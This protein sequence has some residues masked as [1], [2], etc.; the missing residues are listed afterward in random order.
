MRRY[1]LPGSSARLTASRHH[2]CSFAAHLLL[3]AARAAL[4]W[5][6]LGASSSVPQLTWPEF[7]S[8]I[9]VILF[10]YGAPHSFSFPGCVVARAQAQASAAP[11]RGLSRPYVWPPEPQPPSDHA[12]AHSCSVL[13]APLPRGLALLVPRSSVGLL[14]DSCPTACPPPAPPTIRG[15]SGGYA[16]SACLARTRAARN[17]AYAFSGLKDAKRVSCA[18]ACAAA[19]RARSSACASCRACSSACR[20]SSFGHYSIIPILGLAS[21]RADA[22][23]I[24][25]GAGHPLTAS[26]PM[27]RT[28]KLDL[29]ICPVVST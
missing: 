8:V 3:T 29:P 7:F 16:A 13:L 20:R 17:S 6:W 23:E 12:P 24:D 18:D 1:D 25:T 21:L 11:R 4:W 14:L 27:V 22:S 5:P 19:L 10:L 28:H 2:R 9:E 26:L 15:S